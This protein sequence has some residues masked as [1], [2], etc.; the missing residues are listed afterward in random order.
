VTA[1]YFVTDKEAD[2]PDP[3]RNSMLS[4][5]SVSCSAERGIIDS[6]QVNLLPLTDRESHPQTMDWWM[7]QPE[8]YASSTANA[9]PARQA[10]EAY[11][12]WIAKYDGTRIFA[13]RPLS[14]DEK[15]INSY[16]LRFLDTRTFNGPFEGLRVFDGFGLDI[17]SYIA[18]LFAWP[19]ER[20][21]EFIHQ[22]GPSWR[23]KSE[24]THRAIDDALGYANILVNAL[25]VSADRPKH[26]ADFASY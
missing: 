24:H 11:V 1:T 10:I 12:H 26:P 23:G 19:V 15:W 7:T 22:A 6:Y 13:A 3:E 14:F 18:G 8:A 25:R 20:A 9:V 16:L 2:G 4:F 17:D 21:P 5:A